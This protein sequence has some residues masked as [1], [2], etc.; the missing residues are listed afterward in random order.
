[1]KIKIGNVS[2]NVEKAKDTCT[3]EGI[4]KEYRKIEVASKIN[5]HFWK[6]IKKLWKAIVGVCRDSN[7]IIK[8]KSQYCAVGGFDRKTKKNIFQI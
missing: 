7:Q 5:R 3:K 8:A 4:L 6:V 1:M 2:E